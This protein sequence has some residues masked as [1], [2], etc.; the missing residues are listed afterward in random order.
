MTLTATKDETTK[1][2]RQP[3]EIETLIQ[4]CETKKAAKR[5]AMDL[6]DALLEGDRAER[7]G[8]SPDTAFEMMFWDGRLFMGSDE[9]FDNFW[10]H[11]DLRP[12]DDL[13]IAQFSVYDKKLDAT[14]YLG[15]WQEKWLR[16]WILV[17]YEWKDSEY[18]WSGWWY[19]AA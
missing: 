1:I 5:F 15:D 18:A 16:R 11:P 2:N 9:M 13:P 6:G 19:D 17:R 7:F 3:F 10:F 4:F 12:E 14:I 8:D